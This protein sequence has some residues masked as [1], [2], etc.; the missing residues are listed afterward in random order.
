MQRH[1]CMG[2]MYLQHGEGWAGYFPHPSSRNVC[3]LYCVLCI[4][5]TRHPRVLSTHPHNP[6]LPALPFCMKPNLCTG[7][8]GPSSTPEVVL[9][10]TTQGRLAVSVAAAAAAGVAPQPHP[11]AAPCLAWVAHLAAAPGAASP[12]H[13]VV[14]QEGTLESPQPGAGAAAACPLGPV[15]RVGAAA[16]QGA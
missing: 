2:V 7:P 10:G 6:A 8:L 4:A 13:P 14:T 12:A 1:S 9:A 16:A 15:Q 3:S 11:P 5:L